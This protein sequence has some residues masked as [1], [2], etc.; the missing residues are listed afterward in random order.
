M[1]PTSLIG[2]LSAAMSL[3]FL[4][5]AA[6]TPSPQPLVP[7][8]EAQIG[9]DFTVL[10]PMQDIGFIAP[11]LGRNAYRLIACFPP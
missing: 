10:D 2:S 9:I 4:R 5:A 3:T 8:N 1:L 7:I 11:C 6:Q